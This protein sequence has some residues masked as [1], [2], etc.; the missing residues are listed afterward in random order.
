MSEAYVLKAEARD[1]AGKGAAR[2][3]R[4]NGKIPAVIY[5]DKKDP[6]SITL[7]YKETS[8][9]IYGGGFLTTVAEIEV[10]G[11]KHR[12]LPKSY[13]LDPVRDFIIHIDFLRVSEKTTVTV[14]IPVHFTNEEE[15]PGLTKGGVLNVVRHEV[16]VHCPAG[17]IPEYFEIDLTGTD[18]G[19]ALKISSVKM[20]KNVTP[21]ITDRDFTIATIATPAALKS[22][23][24]EAEEAAADEVEVIG[25]GEEA[26]GEADGEAAAEEEKGEE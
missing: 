6:V 10:D 16:E 3:I 11:K 21:T 17:A 26:E 4:R 12:V 22:D 5:G 7:P 13:D 9:K 24:D 1:R 19:D 15:S 8:M 14:N 20:P 2:A 23:E 18:V 25:E